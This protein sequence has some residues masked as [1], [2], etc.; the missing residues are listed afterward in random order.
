MYQADTP[1]MVSPEVDEEF[2]ERL[3][4]TAQE[5]KGTLG[6]SSFRYFYKVFNYMESDTVKSQGELSYFPLP[7]KFMPWFLFKTELTHGAEEARIKKIMGFLNDNTLVF[8]KDYKNY[9]PEF[10]WETRKSLL[11]KNF[12]RPTKHFTYH[13]YK[14]FTD[15]VLNSVSIWAKKNKLSVSQ[16]LYK[17]ITTVNPLMSLVMPKPESSHR[18]FFVYKNFPPGKDEY[19]INAFIVVNAMKLAQL[20]K[21]LELM[22]YRALYSLAY[23]NYEGTKLHMD[24]TRQIMGM[25]TM[26]KAFG[27]P[28][29][30]DLNKGVGSYLN[31]IN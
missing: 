16:F 30:H 12:N 15:V 22:D 29:I 26:W 2:R 13:L 19:D 27:A 21:C 6:E 3:K 1:R 9:M 11:R 8:S 7:I 20:G 4:S 10:L 18:K 17:Y 5:V 14:Q 23:V 24:G 31:L 25:V 28:K